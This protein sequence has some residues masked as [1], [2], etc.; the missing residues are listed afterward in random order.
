[1]CEQAVFSKAFEMCQY[2]RTHYTTFNF[3]IAALNFNMKRV[4]EKKMS[5]VRSMKCV[6]IMRSEAMHIESARVE[7]QVKT[8][9]LTMTSVYMWEHVSRTRSA[10][11]VSKTEGMFNVQELNSK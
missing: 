1:M 6:A 7:V 2:E 5:P 3:N 9:M 11:R 4:F 10:K 8:F